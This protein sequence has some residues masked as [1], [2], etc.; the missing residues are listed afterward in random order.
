MK[1]KNARKT[2]L[3]PFAFLLT[4]S[5]ARAELVSY[6]DYDADAGSFT[7]AV[8]ECTL[9]TSETRTLANGWYAVEDRVPHPPVPH[10]GPVK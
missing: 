8:R 10:L 3:L 9:V 6:R 4:T 5:A 2:F 1:I 7:N